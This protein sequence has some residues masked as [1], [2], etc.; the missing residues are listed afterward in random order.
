MR[1]GIEHDNGT[2]TLTL[3]IFKDGTDDEHFS[4]E[5]NTVAPGHEH[6][7]REHYAAFL[8]ACSRLRTEHNV[9]P[10]ELEELGKD[11]Y[12][13]RQEYRNPVVSSVPIEP[14]TSPMTTPAKK[15]KKKIVPEEPEHVVV[16]GRLGAVRLPA[17]STPA[18]E[19][20]VEGTVD[21]L[22]AAAA[23]KKKKAPAKKATS[24]RS[25]AKKTTSPKS[26]KAISPTDEET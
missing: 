15:G 23:D 10:Q 2:G 3:Y 25:K 12:A 18:D 1:Y 6:F 20:F 24:P 17:P 21:E 14:V 19:H 13:V 8:N 9:H 26:K 22:F 16:T 5:Y 11:F 4:F 7:D